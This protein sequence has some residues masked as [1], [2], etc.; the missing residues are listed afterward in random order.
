M[1]ALF[2]AKKAL[3]VYAGILTG[4]VAWVL[5]TGAAPL[6]RQGT[7]DVID[8]GRINIREP[9]GTLRMTLASSAQAPGLF[10]RGKEHPRPD[11]RIA[12]LLFFN[13]E[14]TENGGLIFAGN[15]QNGKPSS[16][17]SL[18][19]DRY[20][21]DQIVQ[22]LGSENGPDVRAGLI[23]NDQPEG[24]TDYDAYDRINALPQDQ[25]W[26]ARRAAHLPIQQERLFIG[27]APDKSSQLALRDASGHPRLVLKV[28]D[29]GRASI[30]FL[31]TAGKVVR[32]VTP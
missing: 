17:G 25:R 14:G 31:D 30:D 23:V 26:A 10:V 3:I 1:V 15:G 5:L 22:L 28:T 11:R 18:T 7:F 16:G 19:F 21:S 8:V 13:D 32:T 6:A 12:G 29:D 4:V 9:D 24:T 27:R 2:D 20:Q